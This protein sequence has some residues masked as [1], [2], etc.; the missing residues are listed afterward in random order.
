MAKQPKPDLIVNLSERQRQA[1]ARRWD[2]PGARKAQSARM[3]ALWA[4][5]KAAPPVEGPK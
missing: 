4:R 3:K 2:K 1:V 5:I